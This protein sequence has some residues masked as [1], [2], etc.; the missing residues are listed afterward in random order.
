MSPKRNTAAF[1]PRPRRGALRSPLGK[2][3]RAG[4]R[5]VY[6][7]VEDEADVATGHLDALGVRD[8]LALPLDDAIP[9]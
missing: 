5:P 1:A 6:V 2:G 8:H 9:V 4:D 7:A 3:E